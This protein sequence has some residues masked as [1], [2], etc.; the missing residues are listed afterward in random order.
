M[1]LGI[2]AGG[3]FTDFV[4]LDGAGRVRMHKLLTSARD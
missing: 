2:D 3:T 1:I 4:L